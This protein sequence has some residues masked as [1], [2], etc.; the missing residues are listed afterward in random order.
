MFLLLLVRI[1]RSLKR[2]APRCQVL[3]IE[4]NVI[5]DSLIAL[6]S[7]LTVSLPLYHGC[8]FGHTLEKCL[9]FSLSM[10]GS[11]LKAYK[12]DFLSTLALYLFTLSW[13][14]DSVQFIKGSNYLDFWRPPCRFGHI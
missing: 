8:V 7:Q 14:Q 9:I 2:G 11:L 6:C 13:C 1:K 3:I 12:F 10:L 5:L 4:G